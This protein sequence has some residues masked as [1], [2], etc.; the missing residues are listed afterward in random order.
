MKKIITSALLC[1]SFMSFA[2]QKELTLKDAIRYALEN[3]ADAEKARLEV[4]KSEYKIQEVRANALPNISASGGMVYNPKLQA[5]YID[6][7]TFAFPGMPAS[8]EPIKMEMG[9][10]WS[11]NAE[12]KLTQVLFNQTVFMGLKAARTTREFYMLNQQLTENEIIEK[13][14]QAYYQVYQ[15]RQTLENIESNLALTEKTANV[16]KGLNQ[17]GLS[18]KID[19]DRTTVAVNNLKSARQ[20]A[21][22][23]VQL[24]EN[25]LKYMI[26]MPMSEV[27]TLPKEGFEANYDLAFEKGNSNTRI[28]LQ[29]LEKQKQLL[30]LNTKVQRAAL[31]PSLALQATY[32]YL[33][34]GPKTPIIYGKKDKV[35]GADYSAITLGVN[36]PIFSGFGTRAKIHQAQI[37]SQALEATL[38]DTRLA[39]DLAYEN[40]HSQLTNNLLTIDSQK[41]NVKLA[42]EVLLNTQNNYQQGL[43]SLTDLL[44]AERSLSDAKNNYTNALLDYKLAEIQLLKSQG[45]LE[46][47]K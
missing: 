21:L 31:Y 43:A 10:K 41:E 42:E 14:A 4:T 20:Q 35:Y 3:K 32:G 26:G 7:S 5:T 46:T 6:A 19:V 30:D 23:G 16:V 24:S 45:K 37:E 34:M 29:V 11:A 40:A 13:V 22:N 18:K 15:T 47:M 2:Q 38:K 36:I 1:L 12:A 8:N 27:I 44:E 39:M 33:S 9:Q 28:E 17:S 25:A